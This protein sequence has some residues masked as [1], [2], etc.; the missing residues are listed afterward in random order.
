M[1]LKEFQIVYR[2]SSPPS[3]GVTWN[4]E[5]LSTKC[6][7]GAPIYSWVVSPWNSGAPSTRGPRLC[8]PCL[9]YCYATTNVCFWTALRSVSLRDLVLQSSLGNLVVVHFQWLS[10]VSQW[11]PLKTR[12][13]FLLINSKRDSCICTS[14]SV[15][16]WVAFPLQHAVSCVL[17]RSIF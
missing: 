4:S 5:A 1:P 6:Q 10:F 15:I 17:P 7:G 16:C 11:R 8:L 3:S 2:N 9:P 14:L 13:N 12:C